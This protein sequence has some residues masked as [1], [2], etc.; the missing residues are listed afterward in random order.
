MDSRLVTAA[1]LDDV[2]D[3]LTDA[4]VTD[5]TGEFLF[6]D[7]AI[8]ARG[9]RAWFGV[10]AQAGMRRGHTYVSK[11]RLAASVW[12]PPDTNMLDRASG[13]KLMES[14]QEIGGAESVARMLAL[15]E[16]TGAMHPH[17][18]PHFYL[19]FV[20][21]ASAGRG[22][23]AGPLVIAPVLDLCDQMQFPAYL[24]ATTRRSVAFYERLGFA[25]IH[26]VPISDDV[27]FTGMWRDPS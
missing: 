15:G 1:D 8:R 2:V 22:R 9:M 6:P 10:M 24:E 14:V 7:P 16:A 21:V 12:A 26:D 5:P 13:N 23:G 4:F 27:S 17:D 3:V 20:G 19:M 18:V 25:P 11:N